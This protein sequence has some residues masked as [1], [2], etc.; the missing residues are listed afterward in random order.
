MPVPKS[1]IDAITRV[2]QVSRPHPCE[3]VQTTESTS[4]VRCRPATPGEQTLGSPPVFTDQRCH[5][6]EVPLQRPSRHFVRAPYFLPTHYREDRIRLDSFVLSGPDG[7]ALDAPTQQLLE[8]VT[9]MSPLDQRQWI[10]SL[11]TKARSGDAEAGA[12]VQKLV[13]LGDRAGSDQGGTAPD[14]QAQL[15]QFL[16]RLAVKAALYTVPGAN[17]ALAAVDAA[18]IITGGRVD[19]ERWLGG[20]LERL[21]KGDI[22]AAVEFYAR[23]WSRAAEFVFIQAPVEWLNDIVG[24]FQGK[25]PKGWAAFFLMPTY[26]LIKETLKFFEGLFGLGPC[27]W[28][29]KPT[30]AHY[31]LWDGR[32]ATQFENCCNPAPTGTGVML[33]TLPP[34]GKRFPGQ[35]IE[36]PAGDYPAALA[37]EAARSVIVEGQPNLAW[38]L[39]GCKGILVPAR[40]RC[41]VYE[42]PFF[43]GRSADLQPG[44]ATVESLGLAEVGSIQIRGPWTAFDYLYGANLA[45]RQSGWFTAYMKRPPTTEEVRAMVLNDPQRLRDHD[46]MDTLLRQSPRSFDMTWAKQLSDLDLLAAKPIQSMM[47]LLDVPPSAVEIG[48]LA[49]DV[50]TPLK[51][52]VQTVGGRSRLRF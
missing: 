21:S 3:T 11:S 51:Y 52:K 48:I 24:I 7:L 12:T 30:C 40:Y 36:L 4:I 44:V 41:R 23:E 6:G 32:I 29:K 18:K 13:L 45:A 8:T 50:L 46:D 37:A 15:L 17:L 25:E 16:P 20:T 31:E 27:Q 9:S 28:E 1:R 10:E 47:H 42:K 43:E 38:G 19:V 26:L 22:G 5:W 35:A 2:R 39:P 34:G 49:A 33:T 14:V